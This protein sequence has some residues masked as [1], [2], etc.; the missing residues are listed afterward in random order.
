M[1]SSDLYSAQNIHI[2]TGNRPSTGAA[3]TYLHIGFKLINDTL[4][5]TVAD[6]TTE[7]TLQLETLTAAVNRRLECVLTPGTECRFYVDGV[8]KGAITTNLP[9]GTLKSFY[10]LYSTVH[11]TEAADK[12]FDFYEARTF[13]EE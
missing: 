6:G 5:G 11:N 13:Q 3:N 10:M 1:C 4:Y 2:A 9:T 7:T 8:D 12:Y